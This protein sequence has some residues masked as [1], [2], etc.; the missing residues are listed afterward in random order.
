MTGCILSRVTRHGV[1]DV[2]NTYDVSGDVSKHHALSGPD[3]QGLGRVERLTM[4]QMARQLLTYL[5]TYERCKELCAQAG[6]DPACG[7]VEEPGPHA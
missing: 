7:A 6:H 3:P 4:F 5:L 2:S 1:C